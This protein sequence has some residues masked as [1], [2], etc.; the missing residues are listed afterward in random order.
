MPAQDGPAA[1]LVPMENHRHERDELVRILERP[2]AGVVTIS[3]T[4]T[5][6]LEQVQKVSLAG[7]VATQPMKIIDPVIF[8]NLAGAVEVVKLAQPPRQALFRLGD[9]VGKSPMLVLTPE[10][11]GLG[12]IV[13][14][15]NK[16]IVNPAVTKLLGDVSAS[17]TG[18]L[19]DALS[20]SKL[21]TVPDLPYLWLG[22][23]SRPSR[24]G[25][26][27]WLAVLRPDLPGK[28]YAMRDAL[29]APL[30]G[31]GIAAYLAAELLLHLFNLIAPD[32]E[33][34]EQYSGTSVEKEYLVDRDGRV[35]VV[36]QGRGRFAA[37]RSGLGE[38][39]QLA[40]AGLAHA[41]GRLNGIKHKAHLYRVEDVSSLI[42]QVDRLLVR[43]AGRYFPRS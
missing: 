14:Q 35:Q 4:W 31:A 34:I 19:T 24:M 30:E 13:A 6:S 3:L 40:I 36:W 2:L 27:E 1:L 18:S 37:S 16:Q 12:P 7:M 5:K 10:Q 20:I 42:E 15:M 9:L 43:L 23:P 29:S 21:I 26:D 25:V 33:I 32:Q 41:G 8:Q 28:R 39:D 11:I 22:R 38:E 17:I